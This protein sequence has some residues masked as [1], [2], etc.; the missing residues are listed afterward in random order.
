MC[1]PFETGESGVVA[2]RLPGC[3]RRSPAVRYGSV[4]IEGGRRVRIAPNKKPTL[5]THS[6]RA[7]DVARGTTRFGSGTRQTRTPPTPRARNAT[8]WGEAP[9]EWRLASAE[10]RSMPC[11]QITGGGRRVLLAGEACALRR[12]S[13]RVAAWRTRSAE[14]EGGFHVVGTPGLH[15]PRL[16]ATR[17]ACTRP[18]RRH[19]L[20]YVKYTRRSGVVSRSKGCTSPSLSPP[21]R[22]EVPERCRPRVSRG[23][24][25]GECGV[26]RSYE[27]WRRA[28][29]RSSSAS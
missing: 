8:R 3:A 14:P 18:S 7:K 11:P 10:R 16:A 12:R 25:V 24:R 2:R 13:S 21:R 5:I 4:W 15:Y 1:A 6:G 26:G 9:E 23:A 27:F 28:A 29:R 20:R 17:T 22:R 19:C